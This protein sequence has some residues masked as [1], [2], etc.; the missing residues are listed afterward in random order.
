MKYYLPSFLSPTT[1]LGVVSSSQEAP[2]P[3][4]PSLVQP[5]KPSGGVAAKPCRIKEAPSP[6]PFEL[7]IKD[8]NWWAGSLSPARCAR[9][10]WYA[11]CD[12]VIE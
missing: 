8:V 3:H 12:C 1:P 10:A 4:S 7:A 2:R 11:V 6:S 5:Q 9:E